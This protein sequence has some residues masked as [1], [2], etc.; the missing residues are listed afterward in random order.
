MKRVACLK[1][2]IPLDWIKHRKPTI[3]GG[4]C[5]PC[6]FSN[7]EDVMQDFCIGPFYFEVIER[8]YL[9]GVPSIKWK[10]S[11]GSKE[12]GETFLDAGLTRTQ[13]QEKFDDARY[14][15]IN[16]YNTNEKNI[17]K[18]V[19]STELTGELGE[20]VNQFQLRTAIDGLSIG[21][22]DDR[23]ETWVMV[24]AA[25]KPMSELEFQQLKE[26]QLATPANPS[27]HWVTKL[28]PDDVL[29]ED[30]SEWRSP[31]SWEIRH[32]VGEGSFSGMT[33]AKAAELVGISPNNFR[34][35]TAK[36][37]AKTRQPISYAVWHLLLHKMGVKL[38]SPR[39]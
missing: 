29:T 7:S 13:I 34:K 19:K 36:D 38:I 11:Y 26:T 18:L 9:N 27:L 12:L 33:G 14:S 28:L 8:V 32:V 35:Y 5:Q 21:L 30:I 2:M 23:F 24:G 1:L 17:A 39:N 22:I 37:G 6:P 3:Q 16:R 20:T 31:T 4:L 10:M 15:F 25:S